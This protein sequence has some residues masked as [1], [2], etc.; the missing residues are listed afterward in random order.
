MVFRLLPSQINHLANIMKKRS[1]LV[2]FYPPRI[3]GYEN[4]DY[5]YDK[6]EKQLEDSLW[7]YFSDKMIAWEFGDVPHEDNI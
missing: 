5:D 1:F 7:N 2:S 3:E 6:L 4:K